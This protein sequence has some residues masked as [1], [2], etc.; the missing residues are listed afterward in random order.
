M[1]RFTLSGLKM[2]SSIYR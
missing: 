2:A 1:Y